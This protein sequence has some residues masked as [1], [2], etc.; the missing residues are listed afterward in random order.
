MLPWLALLSDLFR[1]C[2]L[3]EQL[4]RRVCQQPQTVNELRAALKEEWQHLDLLFLCDVS[5]LQCS[6]AGVDKEG[7]DLYK[8]GFVTGLTVLTV[9]EPCGL[10]ASQLLCN[11]WIINHEFC[12]I[13]R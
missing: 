3:W 11:Y 6:V 10:R 1:R 13:F 9:L 4:G 12:K 2:H 7:T 5:V 8:N